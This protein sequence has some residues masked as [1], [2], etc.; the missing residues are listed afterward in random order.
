ML[1]LHKVHKM[2]AYWGVVFIRLSVRMFH[3][4]N[5]SADFY[6]FFFF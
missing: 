2:K 3:I 1:T 4:R 5:Y 6:E